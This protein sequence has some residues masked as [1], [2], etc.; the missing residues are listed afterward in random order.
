MIQK[1]QIKNHGDGFEING[2]RAKNVDPY[3]KVC[4]WDKPLSDNCTII[5]R[6]HEH[7]DF[8]RVGFCKQLNECNRDLVASDCYSWFHCYQGFIRQ[9][10][11]LIRESEPRDKW[12]VTCREN[13]EVKFEVNPSKGL[14]QV[15]V[16]GQH[17]GRFEN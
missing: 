11:K 12:P 7:H 14:F 17:K 3:G 16:D 8:L 9:E 10:D 6:V 2:N 1:P 13:G 4:Q 5:F 15:W